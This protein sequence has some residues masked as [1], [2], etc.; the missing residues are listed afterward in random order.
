[1]KIII[2]NKLN[3]CWNL[4]GEF[5]ESGGYS[6]HGISCILP[7]LHTVELT[8]SFLASISGYLIYVSDDNALFLVFVIASSEF[9]VAKTVRSPPDCRELLERYQTQ[10]SKL[11]VGTT[12]RSDG[13]FWDTVKVDHRLEIAV[14]VFGKN[15]SILSPVEQEM[16]ANALDEDTSRPLFTSP[17]GSDSIK[18]G[19]RVNVTNKY[20]ECF[21]FDGDWFD[22]GKWRV[23]PSTIVN[24]GNS[25]VF[26]LTGDASLSGVAGIC[27]FVSQDT[28][29]HYVSIA[30]S[31]KPMHNQSGVFEV[32]AGKPPNDLKS[33]LLKSAGHRAP[34]P[35][36]FMTER[37]G[38]TWVISP[39]ST[40]S[41]LVVDLTI[42]EPMETYDAKDYP[43]SVP[44]S[45]SSVASSVDV[46]P[47]VPIAPTSTDLAIVDT[48]EMHLQHRAE[49]DMQNNVNE[50]M[51]TTRPKNALSGLGS[52]LKFIG[53]GIVAGTAALVSAPIVGARENGAM[54]LLTG[55]AKGVG[56][57]VGLTVGGVAVGV[58]QIA[59]GIANTPEALAK[60]SRKDY[61]WDKEKG[62]WYKDVYVLRELEVDANTEEAESDRE[63]REERKKESTVV[64]ES[65]YYDLLNVPTDATFADIKK[66]YY[67]KAI[68]VHPDKNPDPNAHQMFQQLNQAYQVLSDVESRK[69]Y[70]ALGAKSFEQQGPTIDPRAFFSALFGSQKFEKY[71][72]ELSLAS[73]AKQIMKDMETMQDQQQA[74]HLDMDINLSARARGSDKRRQRRRRIQCATN[75]ASKLN[76]YV[77]DRDE[78]GFVRD[79]YLE[80]V[81]LVKTSFGPQLLSTIAWVYTYRGDKFIAEEKGNYMTRKMAGWRSTGRNYSNMASVASNV[82]K[83]FFAVNRI[84]KQAAE[85]QKTRPAK[86]SSESPTAPLRTE[87]EQEP[88]EFS[89]EEVGDMRKQMEESL[90]LLLETAWSM[91]QVD[92][93]DTVKDATKMVLKDIGVPW[94][95]RYRRAEALRRL[96]RVFEDVAFVFSQNDGHEKTKTGEE[97]MKRVEEAL[98]SSV[99]EKK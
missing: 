74:P 29:D 5:F 18:R 78:A 59:R 26:E 73:M 51:D 14:T 54:G 20:S 92:I 32:W 79:A 57:F 25:C 46:T 56:G 98:F 11:Q 31:N 70:D 34:H 85:K 91:C 24:D 82:T 87:G 60:G 40:S 49:A 62:K 50:L 84:S 44:S 68:V 43:P 93:E 37:L 94:Q 63:E 45:G 35:P 90:P 53:G 2:N 77:I 6:D 97:V 13:C 17:K 38:C 21:V 15:I 65:L 8:S 55:V 81:D 95:I 3:Q 88:P 19:V 48:P 80:A 89:P 33:K 96:A 64:K 10:L 1:M 9:F 58:T 39:Q 12:Q 99:K 76:R 16:C 52:G 42:S 27:W 83:S 67:R 61:K 4:I 22:V 41:L 71:V 72:G 47:I 28:K 69:K 36:G 86:S 66:A 7:G 75:L 30:F 23:R